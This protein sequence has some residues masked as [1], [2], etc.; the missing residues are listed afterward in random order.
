[1]VLILCFR[2]SNFRIAISHFLS[3]QAGNSKVYLE[4]LSKEPRV[5]LHSPKKRA[6]LF[7]SRSFSILSRGALTYGGML[8]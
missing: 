4:V 5:N 6:G 3:S 8:G 7:F 2:N 1:M